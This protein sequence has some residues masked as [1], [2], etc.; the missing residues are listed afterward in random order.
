MLGSSLNGQH[1]LN[2][3]HDRDALALRRDVQSAQD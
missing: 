2:G 3:P 1:D